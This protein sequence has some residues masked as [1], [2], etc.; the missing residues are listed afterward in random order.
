MAEETAEL[1]KQNIL[2]QAGVSVLAQA[3]N[4]GAGALQ[5]LNAMQH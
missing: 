2:S 5:L 1:T 4:S 3:N